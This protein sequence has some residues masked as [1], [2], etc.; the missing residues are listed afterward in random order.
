MTNHWIDL[1][2]ADVIMIIGSN[3][4]ENHPISFK[5]VQA[6]LDR[7]ARLISVDPRFTR[8]S[9]RADLYVPIRAGTDIAFIGGLI[10]YILDNERY[11]KDY[12]AHY[13]NGAFLLHPDFRFDAATGLFSGYDEQKR[14]YDKGTWAYQMD[15]SGMPIRDLT[16]QD[17]RSVFQLLKQHY[18]RYDLETVSRITGASPQ[19]LEA[20]YQLYASSGEPGRAG[21][22]MYAMGGTQHTYGTQN[23]MSYAILQLLLGNIGVAGGGVNALR[24]LHN[25]QGSTDMCLLFHILPGYLGNPVEADVDLAA[26]L[27]R[28]TPKTVGDPAQTLN[29]WKNYPKYIVSL[30]KA[31]FADAAT[32][33]NDFAFNWLPKNSGNYS[34]IA[35]FE[36][37]HEGKIPGFIVLGQNPAVAGPYSGREREAM[38]RLEWL[39]T[40]DLWETETASFWKRP[41]ADSRA[42]STEVF[43]L[44][45]ASWVERE[46]SVTNS[47][48]W[49]QWRWKA[50]EPPGEAKEDLWIANQIIQRVRRLYQ[51]E[52]R[53]FPEPIVNLTWDY[54]EGT[55][56]PEAV[57]REISGRALVDLKDDKDNVI[58]AAGQQVLN[59]TQLRDDGSTACGNWLYNYY[60]AAGNLAKRR[61]LEDPGGIGLYSNWSW[62]WPV[63]RRIIYNRASVHPETGEPWD[64]E[65]PVIRWDPAGKKWV[66]DVPDGG[67]PPGTIFPFIM[68]PEG[69]GRLFGPGLADGPFPEHYEPFESPVANLLSKQQ[70][71][72]AI[73]LWDVA[74]QTRGEVARFPY[75]ATTYRL[76]EHMQAGAMTRNL[77]WLVELQPE[78]FVELNEALAAEKGIKN[79]A[80]VVVESARGTVQGVAIVTRRLQPL[81]I[82]GQVVHQ[83][84]LPWHWGYAGLSTGDSANSLTPHIGDANTMMPE[85]KAFLCDVRKA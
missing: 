31:W 84:G 53:A 12:V 4:A 60:T 56:D 58:V 23:V 10:K 51:S 64:M 85:F 29:W 18:S 55:P 35:L 82:N 33:E 50:V 65:H 34:H 47:G 28:V 52:G 7:G 27:A 22:I 83:V 43:L 73:K 39:V 78:M 70:N 9:S 16:L 72:P 5:W 67:T 76:T 61:G 14:A 8:T 38:E 75:V 74:V 49:L 57:A 79:G 63:N 71:N 15:E 41:G 1:R 2:N 81:S 48:R 69:V 6:A 45:A 11:H 37:M 59:F 24:G 44:P 19:A 30:L 42:I 20:A 77:P 68:K 26:Y 46:G 3:A 32:P 25:V 17:P 40:I 62:N 13:T 54:G 66:G 21:S 80:Q 36:A